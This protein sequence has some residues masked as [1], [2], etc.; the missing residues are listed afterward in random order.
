[1]KKDE[2]VDVVTKHLR[3]L[4]RE[5]LVSL[6][7]RLDAKTL[8]LTDLTLS[9]EGGFGF[10]Q[11]LGQGGSGGSSGGGSNDEDENDDDDDDDGGLLERGADAGR[12]LLKRAKGVVGG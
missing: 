7:E 9:G 11:S 6:A 4:K 1:M 8:K 10:Q 2:L 5:E 3:R 12:G